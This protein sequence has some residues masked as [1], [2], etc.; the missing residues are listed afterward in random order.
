MRKIPNENKYKVYNQITKQVHSFHT[1]REN[2][3]RQI[4]LLH[5]ITGEGIFRDT[6]NT[7][8]NITNKIIH[9][10]NTLSPKVENIL[11]NCGDATITGCSIGRTVVNSV[12]T[13]L[14]KILST[15]SYDK[16]FH[17]FLIL[18]T[19]K[20]EVSLEKEA[21]ITMSLNP[22]KKVILLQFKIFLVT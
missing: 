17:L 3:I 16:L 13:G 14:I 7:V 4:N 8:K 6:Y 2:A 18:S 19:T 5:K 1:S 9:G 10:R 20:G 22:T 12:I 15:T 11:K 21:V